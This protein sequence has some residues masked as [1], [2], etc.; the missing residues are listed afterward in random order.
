M[1]NQFK[2]DSRGSQKYRALYSA[3]S[4]TIW[5]LISMRRMSSVFTI[6][7]T[8]LYVIKILPNLNRSKQA[9]ADLLLQHAL[10]M[11]ASLLHLSLQWPLQ[12]VVHVSSLNSTL[13]NSLKRLDLFN[14]IF[15][16]L[17]TSGFVP[18]ASRL[19]PRM[20]LKGDTQ[21]SNI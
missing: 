19:L 17:K 16:S 6:N 8:Q 4:R 15:P 11:V 12:Q 3:V 21:D 2:I 20:G 5:G 7:Y 10:R 9:I 18:V 13:V 1:N 14:S